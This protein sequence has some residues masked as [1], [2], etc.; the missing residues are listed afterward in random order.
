MKSFEFGFSSVMTEADG[1]YTF[2]HI[3]IMKS[4]SR[5]RVCKNT[6]SQGNS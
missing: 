5:A 3:F 1:I 4:I 2:F 6:S